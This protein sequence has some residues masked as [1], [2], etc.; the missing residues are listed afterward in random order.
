M[1]A[2]PSTV[3]LFAIDGTITPKDA[4]LRTPMSQGPD[5]VRNEDQSAQ[6]EVL[7]NPAGVVMS[8]SA[9]DTLET[10]Y[11]TTTLGGVDPF[12]ATHPRTGSTVSMRFL[13]RPFYRLAKPDPD[14][15]ARY[16]RA[17]FSLEV[18]P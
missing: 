13:S 2:W 16:W 14:T 5:K 12:T 9:T 15:G 17:F 18:L 1:A 7:D 10:F 8:K 11:V 4:R 6:P 3:P